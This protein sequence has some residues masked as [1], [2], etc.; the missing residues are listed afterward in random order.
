MT[1]S[2]VSITNGKLPHI[3]DTPPQEARH[4]PGDAYLSPA[5]TFCRGSLA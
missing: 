1:D 5:S 4:T 2:K 3:N